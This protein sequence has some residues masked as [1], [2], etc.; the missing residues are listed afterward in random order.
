MTSLRFPKKIRKMSRRPDSDPLDP[1]NRSADAVL[2]RFLA[3]SAIT[4]LTCMGCTRYME[5]S[6]PSTLP[7]PADAAL[8]EAAVTA[9]RP[10]VLA[11]VADFDRDAGLRLGLDGLAAEQARGLEEEV[12]RAAPAAVTL[13][14]AARARLVEVSAP[15]MR[16]DTARLYVKLGGVWRCGQE[17]RGSYTGYDYLFL[18]RAEGGWSFLGRRTASHGDSAPCLEPRP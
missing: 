2:I 7:V 4:L 17:W 5:A 18:P 12:R 3:F 14:R 15:E 8:S 10:D 6:T 16:G 11:T 9:L 1:R 13:E